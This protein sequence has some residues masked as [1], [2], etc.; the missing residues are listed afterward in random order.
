MTKK[1]LDMEIIYLK[2]SMIKPYFRNPRKNE[3]AVEKVTK[4]ITDFGFRNPILID[5][6]SIIIAG[7]T[8]W[9]AALKLN[10]KRVPC[11]ICDDLTEKQIKAL[12]IADNKTGELADWDFALLKDEFEDL[13]DGEFDLESTGYDL[14]EIEELMTTYGDEFIPKNKDLKEL[15][16]VVIE[17]K[18]ENEQEKTYNKIKEMGYKCRLLTL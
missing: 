10:L 15:F 1:K 4:S 9:K 16:E 6:E 2:P 13:N 11:M 17:C 7:H 5:S 3:Q 12:R 14:E 18:N 8:R